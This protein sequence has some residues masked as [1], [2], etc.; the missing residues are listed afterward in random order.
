MLFST[1][2]HPIAGGSSNRL[3]RSND[4]RILRINAPTTLAFG[5]D[6]QREA[7]ILQGIQ[8][9]PWAIKILDNQPE[10]GFCVM[11]ACHAFTPQTCLNTQQKQQLFQAIKQLQALPLPQTDFEY[12]A[13]Q[14]D[15]TNL[16]TAYAQHLLP[17]HP[18][19]DHWIEY[20]LMQLAALPEVTPTWVHHDLHLGNLCWDNDQIIILDWEYAGLANPWF[21]AYGLIQHCG[22]NTQHVKTLPHFAALNLS[23]WQQGLQITA[24]LEKTLEDLWTAARNSS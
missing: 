5:A 24:E 1:D 3:L 15:Y 22:L 7:A 20:F 6:R 9:Y 8:P 12:T 11:Q 2:W 17:Q 13:V 4:G 19:A 21:D 14:L 23:A 16:M 18:Q 10:R